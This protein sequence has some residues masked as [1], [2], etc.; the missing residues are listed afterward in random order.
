MTSDMALQLLPYIA[1]FVAWALGFSA[2][3]R[4]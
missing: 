1:L 2:G 4:R 3:S